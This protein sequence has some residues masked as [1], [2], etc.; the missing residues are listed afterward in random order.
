MALAMPCN[1]S[2]KS[3]KGRPV[4]KPV[5]PN[6]NLRVSW[7]PVNPRKCVW[8]TLLRIIMKTMLQEKGDNSLQHYDLVHKFIPVPQAT[9]ITAA[10]A[11]VDQEWEKLEKIQA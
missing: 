11:A 3:N 10:K 4:A 2:K 8:K 1:T 9:K 5:R 7:K 6:Q